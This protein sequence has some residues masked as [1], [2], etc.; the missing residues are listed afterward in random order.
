MVL[1]FENQTYVLDKSLPQILPKEFL[2][3]ERLTFEKFTQ[4]H[5]NNRKVRSIVVGSMSN[6]IQEQYAMTKAFFDARMIEGSSVR[7]HG[8]MMLSLVE[9]LKD[10][11]VDF[12]E[13]KTYIDVILQLLP[14]S[15]DQIIINYNMNGLEESLH[16]L[17]NMFVQY[18]ATIEKSAPLVL[19]GEASTSK[20]KGKVVGR[21][22]R[23]KDET[24]ST[25]TST[26]SAPVTPLGRGKGKRKRVRQ[27]R[28]PNDVCIYFRD[29]GRWKREYPKLL[30]NKRIKQ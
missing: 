21:E 2:L 27:S 6:E 23:K 8:V 12:E 7:E 24:S 11:H 1:D 10:L 4:L 29:K 9:K 28:I 15:F 18:E 17:I 19:V 30:S 20:A 25:T 5:E 3:G 16:E 22:K 13:E 14:P 26:L